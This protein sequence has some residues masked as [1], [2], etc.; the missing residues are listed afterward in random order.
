MKKY[1]IIKSKHDLGKDEM[2]CSWF[3]CP[4]CNQHD[5]MTGTNFCPD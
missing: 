5:I 4:N 2:Y 3:E 1:V